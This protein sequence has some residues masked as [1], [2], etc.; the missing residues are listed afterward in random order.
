MFFPYPV[1]IRNLASNLLSE[2][3]FNALDWTSVGIIGVTD[4]ES[5]ASRRKK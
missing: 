5:G 4:Y 2:K 3:S 1:G